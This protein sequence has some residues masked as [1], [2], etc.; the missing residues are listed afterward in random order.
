[1]KNNNL[2]IFYT[3]KFKTNKI[4]KYKFYTIKNTIKIYFLILFFTMK[5]S[6]KIYFFKNKIFLRKIFN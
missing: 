3:M 4:T 5:F 6:T 2:K 1:M